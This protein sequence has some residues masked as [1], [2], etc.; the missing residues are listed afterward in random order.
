MKKLKKIIY[1]ILGLLSISIGAVVRFVPGIPT[2]PFIILALFCF[3][4]SSERWSNWLK[5]TYLYKKYLE[6][7][8]KT[9]SMSRKQKLSIQIFA[10]IMM[11]LSFIAVD[12]VMFRI[13]MVVLFLAHHYVFIFRIKTYQSNKSNEEIK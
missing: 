5:N 9:K 1:I 11:V 4:K 7:Y 3:N 10:S 2:T 8:I 12:N 13:V 6:D